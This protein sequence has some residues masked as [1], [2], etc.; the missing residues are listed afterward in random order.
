MTGAP[1]RIAVRVNGERREVPAGMTVSAL[2]AE[3]DLPAT[4][5]AVERN[6]EILP[7]PRYAETVLA[8]EDSFEIVRF[9]GGG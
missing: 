7:K 8:P 3:L 5:V 1:G 4:T 9:V 2:L 6:R